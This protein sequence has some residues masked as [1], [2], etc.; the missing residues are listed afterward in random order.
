MPGAGDLTVPGTFCGKEKPPR[1]REPGAAKGNGSAGKG[2]R[3]G[4]V[5]RPDA[6][7]HGPAGI[8]AE[9]RRGEGRLPPP[10]AGARHMPGEKGRDAG[11]QPCHIRAPWPRQASQGLM[12]MS[13]RRISQVMWPWVVPSTSFWAT[14][15]PSL[16]SM[17]PSR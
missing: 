3:G 12:G 11:P 8:G 2:R 9:R 17:R 13:Y 6:A 7:R 16:T 14:Y 4:P 5:V 10:G 15:S 1:E